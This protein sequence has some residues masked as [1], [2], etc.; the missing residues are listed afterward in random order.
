MLGAGHTQLRAPTIPLG[1]GHLQISVRKLD[2]TCH[3]DAVLG[4]EAAQNLRI[5]TNRAQIDI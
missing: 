3:R 5:L 4:T 2:N 1:P